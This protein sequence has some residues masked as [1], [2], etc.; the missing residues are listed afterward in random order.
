MVVVGSAVFLIIIGCIVRRFMLS[1]CIVRCAAYMVY[2]MSNLVRIYPFFEFFLNRVNYHEVSMQKF[3]SLCRI[4]LVYRR[5]GM[6]DVPELDTT[7][8]NAL[9]GAVFRCGSVV[10]PI[11][12]SSNDIFCFR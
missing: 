7:A 10:C 5:L 3:T 12:R 9:V 2:T 1:L 8:V 11:K 6:S 4:G